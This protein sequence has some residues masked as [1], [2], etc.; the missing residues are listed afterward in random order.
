MNEEL[1]LGL[2]ISRTAFWI[3]GIILGIFLILPLLI[4]VPTSW[5]GGQLVEFPPHGFSFQ[6]YEQ[7]FESNSQWTEDIMGS[8]IFRLLPKKEQK[9]LRVCIAIANAIFMLGARK[10]G[11]QGEDR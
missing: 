7:V 2:G 6:W 5:N 3:L 4:I 10:G 1:K 9:I 11:G 8:L